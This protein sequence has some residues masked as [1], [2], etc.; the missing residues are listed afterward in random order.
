MK[1]LLQIERKLL[2]Q[3]FLFG[4]GNSITDMF[5]T[6]YIYEK[7]GSL[8]DILLFKLWQF[9]FIPIGALFSDFF[10]NKINA[11]RTYIFSLL[12]TI[13]YVG[14]IISFKENAINFLLVLGAIY[15]FVVGARALPW[16]AI[17]LQNISDKNKGT[18]GGSL[19]ALDNLRSI[20]LPVVCAFFIASGG[21]YLVLFIAAVVMF[22]ISLIPIL[23]I[24]NQKFVSQPL[25]LLD[26][27]KQ[28]FVNRDLKLILKA[29]F[30][31]GLRSSIMASIW[32]IVALT[33]VGGMTNWG[34][35]KT[36]F[37]LITVFLSYTIGNS[38]NLV[39]SRF[40]ASLSALAIFVGMTILALNFDFTGFLIY[41]LGA[42]FFNSSYWNSLDIIRSKIIKT[43]IWDNNLVDEMNFLREIPLCLGRILPIFILLESSVSFEN[44]TVLRVIIM[45]VGI[46]PFIVYMIL[47]KTS[48]VRKAEDPFWQ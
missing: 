17:F 12:I 31:M 11:I 42:V 8:A 27:I 18:F 41:S 29:T 16:N 5:F 3:R 39:K 15:G 35:Y 26:S 25:R 1:N 38:L 40:G 44:V 48:V 21:S 46:M 14:L 43:N 32:N 23:G 24:R 34:I 4:I 19:R 30:F 2:A 13:I 20:I 6:F 10:T 36:I 7:T 37:A 22:F 45:L 47:A 9:V 33:I 28:Y